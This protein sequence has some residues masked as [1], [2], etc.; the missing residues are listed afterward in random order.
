MKNLIILSLTLLMSLSSLG[1]EKMTLKGEG[2]TLKEGEKLYLYFGQKPDSTYVHNGHFEFDLSGHEPQEVCLMRIE[3]ENKANN[4]I[5]LDYCDTYV[6]IGSG[7]Y[8]WGNNTFFEQTVTGNP[9]H[10]KVMEFNDMIFKNGNS[11]EEYGSEKFVN[12]LKSYTKTPDLAAAYALGKYSSSAVEWGFMEDVKACYDQMSSTIKNLP[13]GKNLGKHVK[14]YLATADGNVLEDFILPDTTGKNVSMHQ[15]VKGK[16][17]VLIDLWASWCGPCIAEGKNVK[18]IYDEFHCKGFD[19]LGVSLDSKK[20]SWLAGIKKEGYKW[21]QV[22]DLKGWKSI[23]CT[24]YNVNSIPT[25]FLVD[26]NG[27]V[28]A[29][30]LRGDDLRKKIAEYCNK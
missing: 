1:Q 16:K 26:G 14:E 21:T 27:R 15:F 12:K 17:V 18:T 11:N 2:Q 20:D 8:T 3:S 6:K 24:Q 30:N 28:I 7:T 10:N 4:M 25:M 5:Y 9:T 13:A 19:V 23:V 22:S 29:K